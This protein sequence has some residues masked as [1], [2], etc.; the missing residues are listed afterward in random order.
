MQVKIS[1]R[2]QQ[3]LVVMGWAH[4][5][6]KRI[7][8]LTEQDIRTALR[9]NVERDRE[10]SGIEKL[11]ADIANAKPVDDDIEEDDDFDDGD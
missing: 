3:A 7:E 8:D 5:R 9:E 1:K 11:A 2:S 4:D 6:N 10:I